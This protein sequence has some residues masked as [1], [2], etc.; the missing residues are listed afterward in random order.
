MSV[1]LKA[2]KGSEQ[3]KFDPEF[4]PE[5]EG[6]F[7]GKGSFIKKSAAPA[8]PKKRVIVL[9]SIFGVLLIASFA[10]KWAK[11]RAFTPTKE[12]QEVA[13]KVEVAPP[14]QVA[15]SAEVAPIIEEAVSAFN[16]GDLDKSAQL[17]KKAI[18]LS[19][20]DAELHNNLGL[21]FVKKGLYSNAA[22]EYKKAL[23]I[24]DKCAECY[25]NFGYLKSLL[26]E[27]VEAKKYLDKALMFASDY[28]DPHFNL[29]VLYEKEGDIGNA[30]KHYRQ[31]SS[32]APDKS[33]DVVMKVN[34]R[35]IELA[36]K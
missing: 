35:V 9:A 5:G 29:A 21:V 10:L 24:N 26:G 33:S 12:E 32:L 27:E 23:E 25:N 36:G 1:I 2:L 4:L 30:V 28:P 6:F 16:S 19:G 13:V 8:T 14:P 15:Q 22:D 3:E 11:N 17:Y 7:K 18:S 34:K 20:D 31:F